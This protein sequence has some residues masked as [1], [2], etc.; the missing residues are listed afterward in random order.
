[1]PLWHKEICK[2]NVLEQ[3]VSGYQPLIPHDMGQSYEWEND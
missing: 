2:K 1:M 3:D